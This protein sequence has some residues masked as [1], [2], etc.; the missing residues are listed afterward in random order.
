MAHAEITERLRDHSFGP[1]LTTAQRQMDKQEE[2][3]LAA[4]L[5]NWS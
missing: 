1:L 5:A 4:L 3:K 2:E